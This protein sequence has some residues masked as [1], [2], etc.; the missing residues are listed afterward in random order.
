MKQV[1]LLAMLL[2]F[3][4]LVLAQD[5]DFYY[6]LPRRHQHMTAK[7]KALV[8]IAELP[9]TKE[10]FKASAKSKPA[11]NIAGEPKPGKP[12][13]WIKVGISNFDMFRTTENYYY[14]PKTRQIFHLDWI[15]EIADFKPNTLRQWRLSA[16]KARLAQ[17]RTNKRRRN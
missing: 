2:V 11:L 10:Q 15:P 13:Y 8:A 7:E 4:K 3:S 9:E 12:Y 16:R 6:K 17:S 5:V 14:Y 1:Y